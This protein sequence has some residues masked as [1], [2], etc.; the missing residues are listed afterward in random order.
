MAVDKKSTPHIS[1][2]SGATYYFCSAGDKGKFDA[3]PESY[4]NG[5]V[6]NVPKE[7]AHG[8]HNAL[9][10]AASIVSNAE[11]VMNSRPS[12]NTPAA[13]SIKPS[14]PSAITAASTLN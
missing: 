14:T 3:N 8:R 10:H 4:V 5:P 7:D 11:V 2:F 12:Q 13:L 1:N 9:N 6:E